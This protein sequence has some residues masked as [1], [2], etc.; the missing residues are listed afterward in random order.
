MHTTNGYTEIEG[1]KHIEEYGEWVKFTDA[2]GHEIHI[3]PGTVLALVES[4]LAVL[5][6]NFNAK[7]KHSR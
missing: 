6:D 5:A 4:A 7:I 1:V 2:A 3:T